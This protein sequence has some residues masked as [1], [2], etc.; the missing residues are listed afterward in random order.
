M[1]AKPETESWLPP[2]Q[3]EPRVNPLHRGSGQ[4]PTVGRAALFGTFLDGVAPV[5]R[6]IQAAT[7]QAWPPAKTCM[8]WG[9][10]TPGS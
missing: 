8:P 1:Q 10:G 6:D 2:P 3:G 4:F 7:R 9:V 5:L